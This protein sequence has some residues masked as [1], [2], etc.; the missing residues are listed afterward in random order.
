MRSSASYERDIDTVGLVG[1]T[2]E[3]GVR[4]SLSGSRTPLS[5]VCV[6]GCEWSK[7]RAYDRRVYY[8]DILTGMMGVDCRCSRLCSTS[9][10]SARLLQDISPLYQ[11]VRRLNKI[12]GVTSLELVPSRTL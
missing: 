4:S 1:K 8:T 7:R 10:R 12:L 5:R 3:Y 9:S 11:K 6:M 2:V